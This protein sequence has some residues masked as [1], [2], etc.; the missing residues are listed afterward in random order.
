MLLLLYGAL[1]KEPEHSN[2]VLFQRMTMDLFVAFFAI[3]ISCLFNK[4]VLYSNTAQEASVM[5]N[6]KR[7]VT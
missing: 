4:S 7:S 3:M 6:T 1:T 2:L 5:D